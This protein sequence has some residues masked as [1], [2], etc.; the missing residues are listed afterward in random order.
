MRTATLLSGV[1]TALGSGLLVLSVGVIPQNAEACL[2]TCNTLPCDARVHPFCPSAACTPAAF[3]G[4]SNC[5]CK[6]SLINQ[7]NCAC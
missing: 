6:E 2:I 7:G 5:L 1:F 3:I 4:C